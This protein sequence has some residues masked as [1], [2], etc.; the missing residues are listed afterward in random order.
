MAF[1]LVEHV[2]ADLLWGEAH[3]VV[4][5]A[6]VMQI[7]FSP[8]VTVA[9]FILTRLARCR[10]V[11]VQADFVD[12]GVEFLDLEELGVGNVCFIVVVM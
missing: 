11:A 2:T 5:L 4:F 6:A 8:V 12:N 7:H 1:K 10:H 9:H 3:Q